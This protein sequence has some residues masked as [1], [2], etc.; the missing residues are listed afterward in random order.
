MR[1]FK[2]ETV[3]ITKEAWKFLQDYDRESRGYKK[4]NPEWLERCWQR[5]FRNE[6]ANPQIHPIAAEE[7]RIHKDCFSTAWDKVKSLLTEKGY[8][9][10]QDGF[11]LEGFNI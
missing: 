4:V 2:N 1:E 3:I 7:I 8:G 10:R 11:V 6:G 5:A 9:Y